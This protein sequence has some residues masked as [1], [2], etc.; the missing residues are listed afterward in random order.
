MKIPIVA[1]I[2][3][4]VA[5]GALVLGYSAG[6]GE[7]SFVPV[8]QAAASGTDQAKP[9]TRSDIENVVRDYLV[10]HPELLI[11]MQTALEAKQRERQQAAQAAIIQQSAQEIFHNKNDAVLG[12]PQGDVTIVE[13]YDYNCGFC[14]QA[15]KD[16]QALVSSDKNLRFVLKEFPVLGPDS[17]RA[18]IVAAAF[19]S[20]KPEKYVEFH[21]RLLGGQGR[22]DEQTAIKLALS[23]GADEAALR[24]A[25]KDPA[26]EKEFAATYDLANRLEITGTPSYVVGNEII[27]GA[28]G[29]ETL[30]QKVEAVRACKDAA[31]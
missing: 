15:L 1:T 19:R 6:S 28:L 2:G 10:E 22:A 16:M 21:E 24:E 8:K 12:N 30:E 18:H 20:L 26:I 14:R 3:T 25:M 23:L 13:F 17:H 31:C 27:P 4:A 5:L 7:F 11:D 29:S 9:W